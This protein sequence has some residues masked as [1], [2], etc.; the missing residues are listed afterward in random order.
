[1]FTKDEFQ[2]CPLMARKELLQKSGTYVATRYYRAY[3]VHLY[4][5]NSFYAELWIR[6]D[7][8]QICWIEVAAS[9]RVAEN[10]AGKIDLG[11]L[12]V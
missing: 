6:M 11:E 2:K 5:V 1:M 4:S 12:G 9:E 8:D 7:F 10:Y 3:A